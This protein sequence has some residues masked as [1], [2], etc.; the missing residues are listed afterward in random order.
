MPIQQLRH[1]VPER[2]FGLGAVE[3]ADRFRPTLKSD[4]P[5]SPPLRARSPVHSRRVTSTSSVKTGRA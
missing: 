4:A 1:S 5:L 3:A 2:D